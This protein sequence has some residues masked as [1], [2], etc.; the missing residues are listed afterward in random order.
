MKKSLGNKR[1][2]LS[3][4]HIDEITK[5]YATF[6]DGQTCKVPVDDNEQERVCSKIFDNREFGFIKLTI[7][8]RNIQPSSISP[9]ARSAKTRPRSTRNRKPAA[10][11]SKV[12]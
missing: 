8:S 5:L 12:S 10:S 6:T 7:G 4:T 1:N 3:E 9:R 2:E 11:C